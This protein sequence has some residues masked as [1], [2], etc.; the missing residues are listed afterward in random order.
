MFSSLQANE[1]RAREQNIAKLREAAL[2]EE[3][4]R[5]AQASYE[6]KYLKRLTKLETGMEYMTVSS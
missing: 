4:E 3:A 6:D 1:L 5:R 2:V